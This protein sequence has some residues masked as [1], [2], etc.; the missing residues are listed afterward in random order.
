MFFSAGVPLTDITSTGSTTSRSLSDRFADIK[1][2]KDFGALGNGSHDDTANIQ[3]AVDWTNST[4]TVTAQTLDTGDT[5]ILNGPIPTTVGPNLS[6]K[7]YNLTNPASITG[8]VGGVEQRVSST[9]LKLAGGALALAENVDIGDVIVISFAYR[10]VIFFPPGDYPVTAPITFNHPNIDIIFQGSGFSSRVS[11]NFAGG[12]FSKTETTPNEGHRIIR[13]L[14]ITSSHPDGI[15][16]ELFGTSGTNGLVNCNIYA[17]TGVKLRQSQ[18]TLIE[19]CKF[20]ATYAGTPDASIGIDAESA[21]GI[22][23][24]NNDI[25]S[26]EIGILHSNTGCQ[27][28]GGRIEVCGTAIWLGIDGEQSQNASVTGVSMESNSTAIRFNNATYPVVIGGGCGSPNAV[29]SPGG[30]CAIR[31]LYCEGA[32]YATIMSFS[33]SGYYTTAGMDLPNLGGLT[34]IDCNVDLLGGGGAAWVFDSEQRKHI[35]INCG[36]IVIGS[37]SSLPTADPFYAGRI[38]VVNNANSTTINTVV[39]AGGSNTVPVMCR[40]TAGT[41]QW[42]IQ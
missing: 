21:N 18:S 6:I 11:G 9:A 5:L 4:F 27:I 28:I 38:M 33:V 32:A 17:Q 20:F 14:R 25:T 22:T 34:L 23:I 42:Y 1:N 16:V 10:G 30:T 3:A 29:S 15:G 35:L 26:Y 40:N 37:V 13:D 39:A 36:T 19:N 7:V 31:G 8:G 12:V 2:V 24:I 41:W